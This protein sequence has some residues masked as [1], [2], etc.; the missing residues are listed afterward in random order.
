MLC[1]VSGSVAGF[2]HFTLLLCLAL[3]EQ[4]SRVRVFAFV[5]RAD[6]LADTYG[7]RFRPPASLRERDEF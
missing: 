5:E 4:F 3:R 1:D 6:Y 7:E 2:S